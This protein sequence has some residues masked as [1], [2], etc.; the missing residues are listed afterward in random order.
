M[1]LYIVLLSDIPITMHIFIL[2]LTEEYNK[3]LE[4]PRYYFYA[5]VDITQRHGA[6]QLNDAHFQLCSGYV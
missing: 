6:I 3:K 5:S 4:F 2:Y 1:I